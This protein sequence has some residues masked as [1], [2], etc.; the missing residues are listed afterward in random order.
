MAATT[1][2][3][4]TR[5]EILGADDLPVEEVEVPEWGFWV[6]VK[7][8]T[9]TERDAFEAAIVNRNGKNV[10]QNLQN[11]RARLVANTL[12]DENG[13]RM[14]KFADIEVLGRKSAKALDRVYE[15]AARLCGI[16]DEDLEE[17]AKNSGSD[18]SDDS[19]SA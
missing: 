11:I 12:V 16:S 14:F 9:G 5:D 10:S 4:G 8:L 3:F 18:Q 17:M 15:V 13:A 1:R 7:T 19:T 2:K 6:R